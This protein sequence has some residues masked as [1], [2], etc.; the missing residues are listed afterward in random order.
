MDGLDLKNRLSTKLNF[1]MGVTMIQKLFL[2]ALIL[3]STTFAHLKTGVYTGSQANGQT[4]Q[5]RIKSVYYLNNVAHPLNERVDV[6]V[7]GVA[8]TIQHP[9]IISS[10]KK[11]AY[12]NH[13][14]FQGIMPTQQGAIALEL[15]VTH[16]TRTTHDEAFPTEFHWI[17]H[18]YKNDLRS[19]LVCAQLKKTL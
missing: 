6:E 2:S 3:S 16:A 8:I 11:M 9:P 13:D 14:M 15:K 10:E 12:F 5:V 19:S 18:I 4:C 7:S 1:Y 17:Q